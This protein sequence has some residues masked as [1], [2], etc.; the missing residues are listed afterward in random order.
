MVDTDSPCRPHEILKLKIKDIVFKQVDGKSYAEILV[1][2][3]RGSRHI[4][5]IHS[6]PY[7]KEWLDAHPIKNNP[8]AP[9][10]CAVSKGLSHRVTTD[11][12]KKKY[13]P[14]LLNNPEVPQEDKN[15]IIVLLS[16]PWNPYFLRHSA[17][18]FQYIHVPL[19]HVP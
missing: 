12:L 4:P 1:N 19:C 15:T 6:I 5:L 10:I 2:G 17:C 8:R 9:F 7:V 16:K 11:N 13:F 14:K 3:K 18:F